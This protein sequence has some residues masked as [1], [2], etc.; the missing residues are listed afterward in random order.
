MLRLPFGGV[1][2]ASGNLTIKG[3]TPSR[4]FYAVITAALRITGGGQPLIVMDLDKFKNVNDTYGHPVGDEVLKYVAKM[5]EIS[6][7]ETDVPARIGGEEFAIILPETNFQ[8]V[9]AV[10]E[11]LRN[12]VAERGVHPDGFSG[13]IKVTISAGAACSQGHLV[14]PEAMMAAADA[15]LYQSKNDGRNR[16]TMA[17]R[18]AGKSNFMKANS[19]FGNS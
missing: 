5:V 1:C 6:I 16:V 15:A 12:A 10:A 9:N 13:M 19:T 4:S 7:R 11:K 8:D 3:I 17:A 14:T 18:V 2:D